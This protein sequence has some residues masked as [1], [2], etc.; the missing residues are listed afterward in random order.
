MRFVES[1]SEALQNALALGAAALQHMGTARTRGIGKV[2]CRLIARDAN[3]QERDLT[4][5]VLQALNDDSLPTISV[6]RSN[7]SRQVSEERTGCPSWLELYNP[8]PSVAISTQVDRTSG[9]P[10]SRWRSEQCHNP[11]GH[12]WQPFMGGCCVALPASTKSHTG[13]RS[14][15]SRFS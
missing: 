10:G 5:Q 2:R 14:I 13:R 1:P 15:L 9:Y 4:E 3:D 7:Q 6:T 8:Y 11:A 12:P